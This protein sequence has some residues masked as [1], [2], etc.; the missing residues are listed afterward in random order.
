MRK[1]PQNS[2]IRPNPHTL[3][4]EELA[5]G[6]VTRVVRVRC[7]AAAVGAFA[8]LTAEQRGDVVERWHAQR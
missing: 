1:R 3:G 6:E 5:K 4:V 8:K 2:H 7:A